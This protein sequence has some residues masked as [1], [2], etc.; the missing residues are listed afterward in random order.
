[1]VSFFT[2]VSYEESHKWIVLF[3]IIAII[4]SLYKGFLRSSSILLLSTILFIV[5]R[6]ISPIEL[7]SNFANPTISIIML[8]ILITSALRKNYKIDY[9]LDKVF[10]RVKTAKT[11]LWRMTLLVTLSSSFLSNTPIVVLMTPYVYNWG[12]KNNVS[13]SKL[14]IPLSYCTIMGGMITLI[15]TSTSL[16]LN[17]FLYKKNLPVLHFN[18]FFYLGIIV[19]LIGILYICTIGYV[20]LP[21]NKDTFDPILKETSSKYMSKIEIVKYSKIDVKNNSDKIPIGSLKVKAFSLIFIGTIICGFVDIFSLFT[22]LL[23]IFSCLFIFN[24]FPLQDLRKDLDIDLIIILVCSLNI[25]NALIDSGASKMISDSIVP[26]LSQWGHVGILIGLFLFT[27]L[28]T[29]FVT[30]VAAVSIS[31][32][33]TYSIVTSFAIDNGTAFFTAIAFAASA[34]FIS[35]IGYQTNWIVYGPGSYTAK[36]FFRV[37]FPLTIIYLLVCIGFIIIYYDLV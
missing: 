26:I 10:S 18:D 14:L 17:G 1:M 2:Q 28:L 16:V 11:F 9:F 36:D 13:P 6:I 37:G 20:L 29:S 34:A 32:P 27:I 5:L 23:I 8:L 4:F 22:S 24:L 25:G 19:S 12:K 15:G 33:I 30:N 7:L 21:K 3:T 35:P 31:F